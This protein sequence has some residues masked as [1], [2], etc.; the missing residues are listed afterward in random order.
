MAVSAEHAPSPAPAGPTPDAPVAVRLS[1]VHFSYPLMGVSLRRKLTG[2][3][4]IVG[5][6]LEQ[7]RRRV[8]VCALEGI[9]LEIRRG[10]RLGIRGHNGAG[11]STLLRLIAGIYHPSSGSVEVRGR[12]AAVFDKMLGMDPEMSGYDNIRVRGMFLGLSDAEIEHRVEEIAEFCEL[13]EYLNLPLRIYS[14]GMRARLGFSVSTAFDAEV[15]VLDEWMGV[16]DQRFRDRARERMQDF[17]QRAG[18]VILVSHNDRLIE[19]NCDSA[20]VME[21][22]KIVDRYAITPGGAGDNDSDGFGGVYEDAM[23][24]SSES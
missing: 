11:K 12:V 17:Y 24:D 10:Q 6:R 16:G 21:H 4:P 13:G 19:E 8:A 23:D 3:V 22:G 2:A 18:T 14:P 7:R 15:L 20:V 9:D 5:G 1:G